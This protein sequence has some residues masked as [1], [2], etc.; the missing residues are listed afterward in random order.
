[1]RA[2]NAEVPIFAQWDDHEVANDWWPSRVLDE[3]GYDERSALLLR[4]APGAHSTNICRR[5]RP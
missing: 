4:P 2:F 5:A 3:K 1:M